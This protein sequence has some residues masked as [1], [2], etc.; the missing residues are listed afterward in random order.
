M[1]NDLSIGTAVSMEIAKLEEALHKTLPDF[2]NLLRNIHKQLRANPDCVTLLKEEEIAVVVKSLEKF[3]ATQIVGD[4]VK[5]ASKPASL[6]KKLGALN[7][8][9]DL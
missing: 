3:S 1:S 2:P 6:K 7:L 8:D 9:E 4:T 5:S